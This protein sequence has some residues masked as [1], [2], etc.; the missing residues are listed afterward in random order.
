MDIS[1]LEQECDEELTIA[2]HKQNR[3]LLEN[4]LEVLNEKEALIFKLGYCMARGNMV[5]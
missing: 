1:K 2:L 3:L 5:K 4:N